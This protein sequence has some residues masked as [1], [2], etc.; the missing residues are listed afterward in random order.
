LPQSGGSFR[1]CPSLTDW[2]VAVGAD[3][4]KGLAEGPGWA[5]FA[6]D[7]GV[8]HHTY[9]R[10]APDGA[11]LAPYYYQ[12]LDQTP[13]GRG[14]EFRATRHDEYEDAAVGQGG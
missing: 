13:R 9:S 14:D 7:D 12:L 11:L 2:S 6:F 10:H 8:V 5:V 3:L 4:E 1:G